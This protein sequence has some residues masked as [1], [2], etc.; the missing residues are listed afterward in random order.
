MH[1]FQKIGYG[2]LS[3]FKEG[4]LLSKLDQDT[5]MVTAKLGPNKVRQS[6]KIPCFTGESV[7]YTR[8]TEK[9]RL[10]VRTSDVPVISH[11]SRVSDGIEE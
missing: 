10:T 7:R 2:C 5:G 1:T 9:P 6:F 8:V 3:S 4:W 11:P